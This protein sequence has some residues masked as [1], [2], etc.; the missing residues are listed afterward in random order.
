MTRW[1]A[2]NR[3]FRTDVDGVAPRTRTTSTCSTRRWSAR[4]PSRA[5]DQRAF[6]RAAADL[7]A[8]GDSR[9]EAA[10]QL[11]QSQRTLR[12]GDAA[13]RRRHPRS[14]TAP[15]LQAFLPFQARVAELGIYNSLAQLLIKITAPGVP[16]FYQGTELWDL[17]L[18][19]PDNRRPVDYELRRQVLAEVPGR[20]TGAAPRGAGGRPRQDVRHGARAPAARGNPRGLRPGRLRAAVGRRRLPDPCVCVRAPAP[21][22][23][24]DYLRAAARRRPARRPDRPADRRGDLAGHAHPPPPRERHAGDFATRSPVPRSK[25]TPTAKAHGWTPPTV[26]GTFPSPCSFL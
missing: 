21:G 7:H 11:D 3:R 18:V 1:R 12:S 2:L 5:E 9:G 4:G 6:P 26:F 20:L 25:R 23:D 8:Q 19:D 22:I 17:T 14:A 24:G 16:D 13:V 10:Y 15:F